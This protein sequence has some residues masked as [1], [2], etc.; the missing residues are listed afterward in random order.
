MRAS[1]AEAAVIIS[2]FI[3]SGIKITC[4]KFCEI[5]SGGSRRYGRP[6]ACDAL[7]FSASQA[8]FQHIPD[9]S[10]GFCRSWR[11]IGRGYKTPALEIP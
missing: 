8:G 11:A 10:W 6:P 5:F 4:A 3:S 1:F 9:I 7:I 2:N